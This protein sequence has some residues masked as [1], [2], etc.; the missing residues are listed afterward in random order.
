ML[1]APQV[2]RRVRRARNN[3]LCTD[4]ILISVVAGLTGTAGRPFGISAGAPVLGGRH[5]RRVG[6]G[7]CKLSAHSANLVAATPG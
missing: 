6:A 7:M 3:V 1:S 4:A 2:V 5:S